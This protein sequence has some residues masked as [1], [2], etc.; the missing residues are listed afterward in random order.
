MV[1]VFD[2]A[3]N[4]LEVLKALVVAGVIRRR[5]CKSTEAN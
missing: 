3:C 4:E 5:C 1:V 2:S